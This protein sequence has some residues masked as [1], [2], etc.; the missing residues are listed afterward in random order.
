MD[1]IAGRHYI[2]GTWTE[3]TGDVI[4]VFSPAT[5]EKIGS[6]PA[7]TPEDV[8]AAVE[9]ARRAFGE[10][11]A[12]SPS[13]R[14][15]LLET[16]ATRLG[17]LTEHLSTLITAELGAPVATSGRVNVGLSTRQLLATAEAL[18]EMP[19]HTVLD[20]SLIVRDPIGPVGAITPWNFP[21]SQV[22]VKVAPALAAGCTVVLKPS[23]I[24]PLAAIELAKVLD[25]IGLP[26]GVF[27]LVH[28]FGPVVG[29]AIAAHPGLA[30]VSFTGSTMAGRRVAALAAA[31][32]KRVTL[33]LGGKSPNVILDDADLETAVRS[34][35]DACFGNA[36]QV[37]SALTRMI[38]PRSRLDEVERIA[39]ERAQ[40]YVVGDPMDAKTTL[41]PLVSERQRQRVLGYIE[42][43]VREGASLL[44]GGSEP[45]PELHAGHYVRPTIFSDVVPAMTIAQEEIFGPVLVIMPYD[46]EQEAIDIANSSTYGLT[47]AVWSAEGERAVAVAKRL[48]TGRVAINGVVGSAKVPFGGYKA[49]GNGREWGRFG[50]EEYLEVK[51]ISIPS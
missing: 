44:C 42:S 23:E 50:I 51:A 39:V 13:T 18:R 27:N 24:A 15:E 35:V 14:A 37:C 47:G 12:T 5:E 22:V 38:V 26:P 45:I 6:V 16:C 40:D 43:G 8:D 4:D 1:P 36:G 20:N 31:S 2:D 7:G 29:E 33:E 17:G 49:S 32:V 46:T 28:G 34:G 48:E 21:L 3:G 30:M 19:E 41:G 11:S 25:E 9:A 10:W